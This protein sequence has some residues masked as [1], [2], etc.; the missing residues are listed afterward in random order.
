MKAL[1]RDFELRN[2]A[3]GDIQCREVVSRDMLANFNYSSYKIG[4]VE[5]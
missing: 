5:H 2:Y 3:R 4:D 1:G